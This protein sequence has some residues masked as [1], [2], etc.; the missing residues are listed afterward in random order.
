[1]TN[2]NQMSLSE[3]F[4]QIIENR[5]RLAKE[6]RATGGAKIARPVSPLNKPKP[7]ARNS[8]KTT[9]PTVQKRSKK[10]LDSRLGKRVQDRLGKTVMERLGA[11]IPKGSIVVGGHVLGPKLKVNS[12]KKRS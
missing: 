10:S 11:P 3:K 1:L 4:Q 6:K 5:K 7:T 12:N 9:S 2:K 8:H